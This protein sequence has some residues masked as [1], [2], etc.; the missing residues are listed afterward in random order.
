M[1]LGKGT[2]VKKAVNRGFEGYEYAEQVLGELK[3]TEDAAE[4]QKPFSKKENRCLKADSGAW[5][6]MATQFGWILPHRVWPRRSAISDFERS[7]P[8][9]Q[10]INL[11]L[12][13]MEADGQSFNVFG[14]F[15]I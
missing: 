8:L 10:A 3:K 11:R 6:S 4:G 13:M 12:L 7:L 2:S 15:P 1:S 14:F 5:Q 9:F